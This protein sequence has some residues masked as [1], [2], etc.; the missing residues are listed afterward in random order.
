[1]NKKIISLTSLLAVS[2]SMTLSM[3]THAEIYKWKDANG[4]VHYS[5][6]PPTHKKAKAEDIEGKILM[7][8]GKFDPSRVSKKSSDDSDNENKN[9][10]D[11]DTKA[12]NKKEA[13]KPTKQLIDYC[14]G[15]RKS[16]KLLKNNQNIMWE[17]FGKKTN[18]SAAQRKQKIK[19]IKSNITSECKGV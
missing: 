14:K 9:K 13:N 7:S 8:A 10:N 16:L 17:Q 15:Q 3:N 6:T 12:E 19:S 4:Q 5:A 2:F 1:M 11:D 18:L